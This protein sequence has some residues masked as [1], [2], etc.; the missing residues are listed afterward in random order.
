MAKTP[1]EHRAANI[2]YQKAYRQLPEVK[3]RRRLRS[4]KLREDPEYVESYNEYMRAYYHNNPKVK[5]RQREYC[6]RPEVKEH[7]REYM[8]EYYQ[9]PEVKERQREYCHRPEVKERRR[10]YMRQYNARKKAEREA[11]K[12]DTDP[13]V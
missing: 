12:A 8:R 2:A 4:A 3:E 13:T 7:R 6:H 9:R 5:E 11:A 10:E 1:E